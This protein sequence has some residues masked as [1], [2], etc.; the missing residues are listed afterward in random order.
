[1]HTNSYLILYCISSSKQAASV[2]ALL[3]SRTTHSVNCI[4]QHGFHSPSLYNEIPE[5]VGDHFAPQ[6]KHALDMVC[7]SLYPT[8]ALQIPNQ[9][10]STVSLMKGM[11]LPGKTLTL[12]SGKRM[13][14]STRQRVQNHFLSASR[15]LLDR[16]NNLRTESWCGFPCGISH[17]TLQL[18]WCIISFSFL[19]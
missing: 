8:F 11:G 10:Y 15:E 7:V 19:F 16:K 3:L 5:L 9:K 17:V 4:L 18:P 2:I 1:M 6:S 14:R 12:N 13:G